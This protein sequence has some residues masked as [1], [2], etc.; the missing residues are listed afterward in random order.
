MTFCILPLVLTIL[1]Y[2]LTDITIIPNTTAA[3]T[4][5]SMRDG[6]GTGDLMNIKSASN[7][8]IY[9]CL[10]SNEKDQELAYIYNSINFKYNINVTWNLE[11]QIN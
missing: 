6:V 8:K 2:L 5:T 4:I 11:K 3:T 9:Q 7:L 10:W 1:L